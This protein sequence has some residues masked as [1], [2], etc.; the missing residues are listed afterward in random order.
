MERRTNLRK[1]PNEPG[2]PRTAHDIPETPRTATPS[3]VPHPGAGKRYVTSESLGGRPYV[4]VLPGDIYFS[5][6]PAAISTLLG[7]CV[8]ICLWDPL[9]RVGGITHYL[10]PETLGAETGFSTRFG[11]VAVSVL[12]E[13]MATLGADLGRLKAKVFGGARVLSSTVVKAHIGEKNVSVARKMLGAL[14]IP[15]VAEDTGGDRGRVIIFF[16]DNGS[17]LVRRI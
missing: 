4:H 14:G 2:P 10:L 8:A 6:A 7:S 13:K 17:T 12:I 11:N 15:L 3:E 16:S 9:L 1:D 5:A